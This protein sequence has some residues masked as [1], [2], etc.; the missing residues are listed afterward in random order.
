LLNDERE[1][2]K[3]KA[4]FTLNSTLKANVLRLVIT[5]DKDI[6]EDKG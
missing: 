5:R 3:T 1:I 2:Y 4:R 6:P